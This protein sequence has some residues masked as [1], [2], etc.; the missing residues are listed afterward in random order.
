MRYT[1]ADEK[2]DDLWAVLVEADEKKDVITCDTH[3]TPSGSH[4]EDH[5]KYGIAYNHAYTVVGVK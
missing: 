4:D 1:C 3:A 5:P 2:A